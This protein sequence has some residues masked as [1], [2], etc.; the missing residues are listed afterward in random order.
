MQTVPDLDFSRNFSVMIKTAVTDNGV[1]I[2]WDYG[3]LR[4][5][6]KAI[7]AHDLLDESDSLFAFNKDA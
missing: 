1:L 4:W 2:A 7:P 5:N 6:T 3:K